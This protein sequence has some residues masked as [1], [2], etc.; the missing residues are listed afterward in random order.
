MRRELMMVMGIAG[1]GRMDHQIV[2]MPGPGLY[3]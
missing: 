1:T 2:E 3:S